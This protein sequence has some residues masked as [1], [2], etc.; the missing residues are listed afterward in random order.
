[1]F[2]PEMPESL[3]RA[4]LTHQRGFASENFESRSIPRLESAGFGLGPSKFNQDRAV[5]GRE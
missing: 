2:P 4:R 5:I 1:M 3:N